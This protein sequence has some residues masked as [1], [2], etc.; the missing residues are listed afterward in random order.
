M[1]LTHV[2]QILECMLLL[3]QHSRTT[4]QTFPSFILIAFFAQ[5]ILFHSM[6]QTFYLAQLLHTILMMSF[7]LILSTSTLITTHSRL[8]NRLHFTV[9][10]HPL[11]KL[12]MTPPCK[13]SPH[14]PPSPSNPQAK[15]IRPTRDSP[16]NPFLAGENEADAS[17]WESSDDRLPVGEA[18]GCKT[19]TPVFEEKPTIN[20]VWYVFKVLTNFCLLTASLAEAK[21]RPSIIPNIIFPS[22]LS[23]RL[24]YQSI[25]QISKRL[26]HI[27]PSGSLSTSSSASLATLTKTPLRSTP[28]V[29][30]ERVWT[31]AHLRA[32]KVPQRRA[33][34][35]RGMAIDA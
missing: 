30:N 17:G 15:K 35:R 14:A 2:I 29:P 5:R 11:P 22:N 7:A 25:I 4:H 19:S 20:Y 33:N 13:L 32:R 18:P 8:H 34:A 1:S 10:A 6:A 9:S 31:L 12:S 24:N 16:N 28:L 26:R 23:R 27:P 3:P 21:K